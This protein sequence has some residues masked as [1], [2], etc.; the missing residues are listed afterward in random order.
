MSDA[1]PRRD[2]KWWGWGDPSVEAGL[3]ATALEAL[4]E[5]IGTLEPSPRPDTVDDVGLPPAQPLPPALVE[6]AG[7]DRIFTSSEDRVR[8]ATGSGYVDLAR[9]R[10]G[11]LDCAPDAIVLPEA[12]NLFRILEVCSAERVAV[13]PFGGGT[14]VV[15]GVE[16]LRGGPERLISLDLSLLR[17]VEVDRRS[18]TATLGAGLR[19]PEAEAALER[20]GV[21]LGHYPQSFEYATVGGFAATRSAGQA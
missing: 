8:H 3:D 12:E 19:G 13:V 5:R 2:S 18:L 14:S 16:A 20:H 9:L 21:I 6:A 4:A 15:G 1:A 17:D 7:A 10:L 11:E